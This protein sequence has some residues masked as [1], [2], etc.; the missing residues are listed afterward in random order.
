MRPNESFVGQP[1]R[2]LQTM[3][4]V[5]AESDERQPSVVPDGIYSA[6]TASAVSAFQRNHGLPV[7]GIADQDTWNAIVAAYEPALIQI[8]QTTP[9]EVV[10]NPNQVIRSGENH[11]IVYI[12]QA[13]LIILS[14]AYGSIGQS[15]VTGV[16]D[17]PTTQSLSDFQILNGLPATGELDRIT[18]DRL[19]RHYP[20]ASN[21]QTRKTESNLQ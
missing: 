2:S 14:Q 8:G 13:V 15:S 9:L 21:V 10:L 20:L 12:A 17:N 16:L 6:Q 19:A 1:V 3:L 5:I 11:P 7:T 4:R 18:W